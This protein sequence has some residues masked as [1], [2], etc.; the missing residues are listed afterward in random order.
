MS[1]IRHIIGIDPG[2]TG[3]YAI[4]EKWSSGIWDLTHVGNLP[5][6]DGMLSVEAMD[7]LARVAP[8]ELMVVIERVH[9]MPT[10]G[11]TSAFNFGWISGALDYWAR[12]ETMYVDYVRPEAWKKDLGLISQGKRGSIIRADSIFGERDEWHQ[13]GK[14]GGKMESE[15]SGCAEAA[16]IA[17]H[18]SQ[19]LSHVH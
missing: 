2:K 5:F 1:E 6:E 9:A 13:R 11:V 7:H 15:N 16:L 8:W 4:M 19:R 14:R 12:T 3:A 18:A 17:W 10:D